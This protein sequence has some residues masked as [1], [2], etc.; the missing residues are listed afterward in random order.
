[1]NQKKILIAIQTN[2]DSW[3]VVHFVDSFKKPRDPHETMHRVDVII[4]ARAV[5]QVVDVEHGGKDNVAVWNDQDAI[6]VLWL[7]KREAAQ[8]QDGMKECS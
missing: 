5:L 1:M 3:N 8:E 7:T 4:P 2:G 6:T